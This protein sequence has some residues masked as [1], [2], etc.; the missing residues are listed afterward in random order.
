MGSD[1]LIDIYKI[2]PDF[3]A[4]KKNGKDEFEIHYPE[5]KDIIARVIEIENK[6]TSGLN[7]LIKRVE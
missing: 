3:V 4:A 1:L 6:I 7:S 2:R 5:P